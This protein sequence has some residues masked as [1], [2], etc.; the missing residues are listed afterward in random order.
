LEVLLCTP[1][2]GASTNGL[3]D[4]LIALNIELLQ[5]V[6]KTTQPYHHHHHHCRQLSQWCQN[7]SLI[8]QLQVSYDKGSQV[9]I[10]NKMIVIINC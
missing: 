4:R 8:M 3:M 1:A 7:S 2:Y 5:N 9:A 6:R 10:T